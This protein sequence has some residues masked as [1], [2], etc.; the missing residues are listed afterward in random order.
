MSG[1]KKRYATDSTLEEDGVWVDFG[2]GLKVKIR[3][4]NSKH[5]RETRRRLE[6]PYQAQFRNREMPESLQEEILNKQLAESLIAGWEGV[7]DPAAPEP[8]EGEA[9]KMLP[10][11]PDNILKIV[12]DPQF[13]D[14]REDVLMAAMSRETYEKEA[15]KEAVKN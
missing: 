13:K 6:R 3:R 15:K 12:S 14:F 11:T 2:D 10:C 7:P 8:K 9:E 4:L 5:S 1:F